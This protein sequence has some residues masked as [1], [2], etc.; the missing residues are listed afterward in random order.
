LI[1]IKEEGKGNEEGKTA[2][3]GKVLVT[4]ED[5]EEKTFEGYPIAIKSKNIKHLIYEIQKSTKTKTHHA[6]KGGG[7][8]DKVIGKTKDVKDRVVDTTKDVAEKTKDTAAAGQQSSGQ[9]VTNEELGT[10]PEVGR[11]DDPLI[12]RK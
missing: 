10:G 8:M 4:L 9:Q 7:I 1:K 3:K 2:G 12:S 11:M 5:N 6:E